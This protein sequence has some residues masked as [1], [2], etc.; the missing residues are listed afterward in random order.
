LFVCQDLDQTPKVGRGIKTNKQKVHY[1]DSGGWW[2]RTR[3]IDRE[4]K[5]APIQF[6]ERKNKTRSENVRAKRFGEKRRG[7]T[8]KKGGKTG[9]RHPP[10]N[11]PGKSSFPPH[12]K[13]TGDHEGLRQ[14]NREFAGRQLNISRHWKEQLSIFANRRQTQVWGGEKRARKF[15]GGGGGAKKKL[16]TEWL[17]TGETQ[18]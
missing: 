9:R 8:V 1:D 4:K 6:R 14:R 17:R 5:K 3:M 18:N 16:E 11:T 12:T 15:S 7:R 10:I 2:K 13:K